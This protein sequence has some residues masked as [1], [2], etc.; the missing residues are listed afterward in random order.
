M[1][2]EE[3]FHAN[4]NNNHPFPISLTLRF[5]PE[6]PWPESR[7][8][9]PLMGE[10]YDT[11]VSPRVSLIMPNQEPS[12]YVNQSKHEHHINLSNKEF[13]KHIL[14]SIMIKANGSFKKVIML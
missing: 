5:T 8:E 13:T 10:G 4:N 11:P 1:T 9:I 6:G 2:F 12:F 7:G 14:K 3:Q